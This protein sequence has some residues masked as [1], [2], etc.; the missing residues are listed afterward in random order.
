[1]YVAGPSNPGNGMKIDSP[2]NG[3]PSLAP[4]V[5]QRAVAPAAGKSSDDHVQGQPHSVMNADV[6]QSGHATE[7]GFERPDGSRTKVRFPPAA[8]KMALKKTLQ[9]T[10]SSAG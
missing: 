9:R 1:M 7:P 2:K 6:V 5:L 3:C 8:N 4:D 10:V